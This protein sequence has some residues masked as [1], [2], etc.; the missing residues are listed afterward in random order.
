[1]VGYGAQVKPHQQITWVGRMIII[2]AGTIVVAKGMKMQ[3][4]SSDRKKIVTQ[5][6]GSYIFLYLF[7]WIVTYTLVH[8]GD[9]SSGINI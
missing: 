9:V 3:L 8:S 6:I 7:I 2:F 1:M 4:P 5:G